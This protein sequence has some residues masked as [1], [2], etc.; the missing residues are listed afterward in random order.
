[1]VYTGKLIAPSILEKAGNKYL[2]NVGQLIG[3]QMEMYAKDE[4]VGD[5][6]H[7]HNIE[8]KRVIKFKIPEGFTL[9]GI[10]ALKINEIYPLENQK[11]W[12]TSDYKMDGDLIEITVIEHYDEVSFGKE[13][14]EDFKRIIN[15]AA[16]FNKV[17]LFLVK[18]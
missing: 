4:R 12:F 8:Y 9:S 1:M 3:P 6:E 18:D 17:V 10:E 2:F 14:V 16:N 13:E 5:I 11:I 15:A 7:G